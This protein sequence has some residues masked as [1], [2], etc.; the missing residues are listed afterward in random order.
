MTQVLPTL[1]DN[2]F[3]ERKTSWLELFFDLAYVGAIA[4]LTYLFIEVEGSLIDYLGFILLFLMV[5]ISWLGMTVYRNLQGDKEDMYERIATLLQ[6][7]F[8]LVM[9]VFLQS[10]YD[11]GVTGFI[12]GYVGTRAI[13]TSLL[14]RS[15]RLRPHTAPKTNNLLWGN[16]IALFVWLAS[17]FVPEPFRYVVWV[18]ALS[19]EMIT[20]FTT[21][22]FIGGSENRRRVLNK[23]HLP[24]RLG[25]FTILVMGES[26]I[27]VAVIN[28][29]VASV[30]TLETALI[31]TAS[32]L[33]VAGLWWLYFDHVDLFARGKPLNLFPYVYAHIP[34]LIGVMFIAV[35]TKLGM[36]GNEH[37]VEP[38]WL[39]ALGLALSIAGFNVLKVATYQKATRLFIPSIIFILLIGAGVFLNFLPLVVT[40]YVFTATFLIYV[41]LENKECAECVKDSNVQLATT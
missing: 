29:I 27:V 15:F 35:G 30:L 22:L 36:L 38:L 5:Y 31:G 26:L 34:I 40:M 10:A 33:I 25:L 9:S 32:F 13:V 39:V 17:I 19:L 20:P 1:T 23:Y 11:T 4:Q 24:E 12:I 2:E 16:R 7:F 28:N 21:G 14:T 6:M 41:Y 37:S 8:A 18:A 3:V